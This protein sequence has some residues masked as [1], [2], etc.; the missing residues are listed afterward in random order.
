MSGDRREDLVVLVA[1]KNIEHI[2][3]GLLGRHQALAI[4]PITHTLLVHMHRDP[5]CLRAAD[6]LRARQTVSQHALVV[7]DREGCGRGEPRETLESQ[8]ELELASTG[9]ADRAAVIVLDPEIERWVWTPSPHVDD[10]LGWKD[11]Q[12]SLRQWLKAQ[13][14]LT[15]NMRKP[16][17]PKEALEAA[18]RQARVPRSSSIYEKIARTVSLD[19]CADPSFQK[20]RNVLVAWFGST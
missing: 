15:D 10:A 14:F 16:S 1:D 2:F 4:R 3:K 19:N 13:G 20:L 11:R 7:F 17:R 8:V 6:F 18:V 9:W 5:G 12:P